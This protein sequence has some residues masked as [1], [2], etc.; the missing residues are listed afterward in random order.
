M[1]APKMYDPRADSEQASEVSPIMSTAKHSVPATRRQRRPALRVAALFAGIGGIE[2]GLHRSGHRTELL[3]EIEPAAQAVLRT[4]FAGV[5]LVGDICA[6][7]ELPVVDLV[8]AGFPCQD[9]SQAGR[10][11]GIDGARSGLIGQVFRLL[12]RSDPTWLLLENVPFMLQLD[13]GMGMRRL[14]SELVRLGFRW[15]YRVVDARAFG[16]PQRRQRVLLL[17]S[18]SQDP[19]E[20]LFVDDAGDRPDRRREGRACGFYWTEGLRGLGWAIDAVPT[21]K[22]GSTIGIPSAPAIWMPD[23]TFAVP[24]IRDGERLQGFPADWTKP[25]LEGRRRGANGP[26]W[27]LVGNAVC[28][29]VAQW[30][31]ERLREPATYDSG[32]DVPLAPGGRW[33]LAAWGHPGGSWHAPVSIWPRHDPQPPLAEFLRYDTTPLSARAT[34]G[35]LQRTRRS[36][37]RFPQGFLDDLERHLKRMSG[38]SEAA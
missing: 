31:G 33:P 17:A 10:T 32:A 34:A 24:E 22:G 11:I 21:L 23:G 28:A 14:T 29:P 37:L 27:K 30:L 3:C 18:R 13:R 19:R 2:R 15:A 7:P 8:T 20:V 12:E 25:A 16:V 5:D 1:L 26:R 4:H 6:L 35:F 38:I 36:N 9:L